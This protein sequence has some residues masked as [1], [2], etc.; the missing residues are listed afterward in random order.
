MKFNPIT[1][2]LYKEDGS[3]IK[4]LNCPY[5]VSWD[6]LIPAKEN[7]NAKLCSNCN[8]H[9]IDT[10]AYSDEELFSMVQSKPDTCLKINLNQ[11]NIKIINNGILE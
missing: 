8:H 11:N 6:K 7:P 3:L 9:I 4:K 10:S 5:K 1:K 2:E